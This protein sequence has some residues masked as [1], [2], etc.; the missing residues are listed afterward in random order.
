MNLGIFYIIGIS[1]LLNFLMYLEYRFYL[2]NKMNITIEKIKEYEDRVVKISSPKRRDKTLKKISKEVDYY[3]GKLRNYMF[4]QSLTLIF[5][6][7]VGLFIIL[8]FVNVPVY[9]PYSIPL[10]VTYH[11]K[12]IIS[13]LFIYILSF[14]LFTPLSLRRPKTI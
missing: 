12:Y 8:D 1:F 6:Y 2:L 3:T 14:L 13:N 4:I 10:T 7:M 9:F 5:V 11:G